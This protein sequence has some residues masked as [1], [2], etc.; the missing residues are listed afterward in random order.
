MIAPENTKVTVSIGTKDQILI[1]ASRLSI[2]R[3]EESKWVRREAYDEY[4]EDILMCL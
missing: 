3:S 1:G 2:S 4:P